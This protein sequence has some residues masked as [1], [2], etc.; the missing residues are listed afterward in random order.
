M[1]SSKVAKD[2]ANSISCIRQVMPQ[3][4][5]KTSIT[6]HKH[7]MNTNNHETYKKLNK[8]NQTGKT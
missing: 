2:A 1:V 4:N 7:T 8:D 3:R 5:I 6:K